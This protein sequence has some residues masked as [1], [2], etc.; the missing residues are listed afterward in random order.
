[1][2]KDGAFLNQY[3][4]W[5]RFNLCWNERMNWVLGHMWGLHGKEKKI[6]RWKKKYILNQVFISYKLKLYEL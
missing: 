6:P 4:T 5:L 3:C 1:M 2:S